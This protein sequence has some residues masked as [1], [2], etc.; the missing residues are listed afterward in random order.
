MIQ[1]VITATTGAASSDYVL[2]AN[3]ALALI[4]DGTARLLDLQGSFYSLSATA[5]TMLAAT[6]QADTTSAAERL[7]AR[8]GA[9][10]VQVRADLNSFL[11]D[12][13]KERLIQHRSRPRHRRL[14]FTAS[15]AVL[16]RLILNW[17]MSLPTRARLLL[18]LAYLSV[19]LCGLPALLGACQQACQ[20]LRHRD[21][22]SGDARLFSQMIDDVIR[23][24]A[25]SHPFNVECK[26]RGLTCWLLL[27]KHGLPA[28]LVV[29]ID[30]YPFASHCWCELEEQVLTDF[31]DR[32]E[33]FTPV[34]VY[35]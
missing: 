23:A 35:V 25:A 10:P 1:Q 16:V 2:P 19:R 28:R 12:L 24:H 6:L 29:G 21:T 18:G 32:C 5:G 13:E 33:R 34:F 15:L 31:S 3:V 4:Q 11:T 7:A 27:R 30:L 20:K 14:T 26:E 22:L 17:P 8:Y 9:D